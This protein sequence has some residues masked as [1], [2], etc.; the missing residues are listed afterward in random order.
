[1]RYAM[2]YM[3]GITPLAEWQARNLNPVTVRFDGPDITLHETFSAIRRA[4]V[5]ETKARLR[6]DTATEDGGPQALIYEVN[7]RDVPPDLD[8]IRSITLGPRLGVIERNLQH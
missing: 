6:G 4:F 2:A 3:D 1:M 7:G 5:N 8:A